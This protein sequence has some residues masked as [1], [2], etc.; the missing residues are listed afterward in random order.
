MYIYHPLP[1]TLVYWVVDIVI[2]G[3][4]LLGSEPMM[5]IIHIQKGR[6]I[7]ILD[8]FNGLPPQ[9]NK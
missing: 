6:A 5:P 2:S 1:E 7:W 4:T 8:I 3:S 9:S